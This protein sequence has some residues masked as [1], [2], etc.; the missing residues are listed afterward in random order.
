[1]NTKLKTKQRQNKIVSLVKNH[2]ATMVVPCV[3]ILGTNYS[4]RIFVACRVQWRCSFAHRSYPSV[5][6]TTSLKNRS[7]PVCAIFCGERY[8]EH[9]L[10]PE[11]EKGLG[12]GER[13]S[14]LLFELRERG[15][16]EQDRAVVVA[17]NTRSVREQLVAI[18]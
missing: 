2:C 16:P 18:V 6:L 9:L 11:K 13:G 12:E 7:E 10:P 15:K 8:L 1:M 14:L 4:M 5:S 17:G 3:A